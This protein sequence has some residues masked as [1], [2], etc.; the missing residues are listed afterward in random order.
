MA[1]RFDKKPSYLEV[2]LYCVVTGPMYKTYFANLGLQGNEKVLEFGSGF[3]AASRHIA[4]T[5]SKGSG[6]L[7]CVDTSRSWME[8]A[9]R[10]L[11]RFS[12]IDFQ[13][14]EIETLP[15]QDGSC[16]AVIIHFVLH[17]IEKSLRQGKMDALVRKLK[18]NGKLFVREP[19]KEDHGIPSDQIKEVVHKSGL[20]EISSKKS[21]TLLRRR[22]YEGVFEKL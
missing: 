19:I 22:M 4:R 8:V 5:L 15:I 12:N 16:D 14:G 7:T 2:F 20:K 21:K 3:G 18:K 11:K 9:K 17:E 10:K 6:H 1:L 13:L